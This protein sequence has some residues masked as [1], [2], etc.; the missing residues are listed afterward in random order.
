MYIVFNH[1]ELY[2]ERWIN[3]ATVIYKCLEQDKRLSTKLKISYSDLNKHP[4]LQVDQWGLV[5]LLQKDKYKFIMQQLLCF[6]QRFTFRKQGKTNLKFQK[7]EKI[8]IFVNQKIMMGFNKSE[9]ETRF[10]DTKNLY[11]CLMI[12]GQEINI[13]E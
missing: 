13:A 12:E 7:N 2:L 4:K 9:Q 11:P 3:A 8:T 1:L 10:K 5:Q 6:F